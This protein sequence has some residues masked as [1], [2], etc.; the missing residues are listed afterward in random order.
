MDITGLNGQKFRKSLTY[1]YLFCI[2]TVLFL[3]P[4]LMVP[5][6]NFSSAGVTSI[7]W[8]IRFSCNKVSGGKILT[9]TN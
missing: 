3:K 8:V 5:K 2:R 7:R 6:S 9:R 1:M 4:I